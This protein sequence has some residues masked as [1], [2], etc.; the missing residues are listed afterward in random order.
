MPIRPATPSDIPT[1]LPMI[2]A[3]CAL[4]QSWDPD[5]YDFLPDIIA[6]Y[7]YWLPLRAADPRS[8]FLVAEASRP[9]ESPDDSARPRPATAG[10]GVRG[11]R[12][13]EPRT[14]GEPSCWQ[15]AVRGRGASRR[16]R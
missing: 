10:R 15:G 11:S 5:R 8:V 16:A 9:T 3:L 14:E 2:R 12:F 13:G 4:H 7:E 1:L 6:R